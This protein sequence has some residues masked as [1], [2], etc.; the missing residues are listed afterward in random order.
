M[1]GVVLCLPAFFA[2]E[3]EAAGIVGVQAQ[4]TA[5]ANWYLCMV[6]ML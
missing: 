4:N 2:E 6:N 5:R 3:D 1:L